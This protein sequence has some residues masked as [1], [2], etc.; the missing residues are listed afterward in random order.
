MTNPV[1]LTRRARAER[2]ASQMLTIFDT[3]PTFSRGALRALA[4]EL[5]R[6][7]DTDNVE[8]VTRAAGRLDNAQLRA[9]LTTTPLTFSYWTTE[10]N[11]SAR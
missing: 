5:Y 4:P 9:M 10:A 8:H 3:M 6:S 7:L 2:A 11:R 1:P